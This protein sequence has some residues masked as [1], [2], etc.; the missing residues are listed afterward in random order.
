M[1]CQLLADKI[2]RHSHL[3]V[4]RSATTREEIIARS[5]L[6]PAI[7]VISSRLQDGKFAGLLALRELHTLQTRPRVIMLLDDDQPKLVVEAFR[8]G[9]TE[10]SA[11]LGWRPKSAG[12]Y[13]AC[14]RAR[15]GLTTLIWST[16]SRRSCRH[17]CPGWRKLQ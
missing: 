17:P 7:A 6:Q 5:K 16:L 12:V 10:S 4:V 9:A 14:T 8:N 1:G 13:S 11:E 15:F 2:Q 3:R